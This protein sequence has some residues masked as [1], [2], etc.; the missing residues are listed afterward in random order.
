MTPTTAIAEALEELPQLYREALLLARHGLRYA[1]IA[2]LLEVPVER[3]RS[4]A[5]HGMLA[6]S[7]ARLATPPGT[8]V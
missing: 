3:V 7:R 5:L 4:A 6:L 8:P 1:E 2:E